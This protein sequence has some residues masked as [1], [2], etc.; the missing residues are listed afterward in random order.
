MAR[1][2]FFVNATID[3]PFCDGCWCV[4]DDGETCPSYLMPTVDFPEDWIKN[5]RRM[6]H[7]NPLSL[8]CDVYNDDGCDTIPPLEVGGAC[9]AEIIPPGNG[10]ESSCPSGYFYR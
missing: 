4:P 7:E 3:V 5:L 1:Q 6:T 9:V 8:N 2:V 10:S